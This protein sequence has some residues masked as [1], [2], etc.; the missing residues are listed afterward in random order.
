MIRP[1]PNHLLAAGIDPGATTAIVWVDVP[2]TLG[3]TR[4][5]VH[6]DEA[7]ITAY[8]IVHAAAT[9][10]RTI[11]ERKARLYDRVRSEFANRPAQIVALEEPFDTGAGVWENRTRR[12][13]G[14]A[15]R[16]TN[17]LLGEHYGLA[18]GAARAACPDA[19]LVSYPVNDYGRGR[20]RRP[21]WMQ[22]G[23]S[24][25]QSRDRT[26]E[27]LRLVA[28]AWGAPAALLDSEDALMALGVVRYHLEHH[29]ATNAAA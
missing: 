7:R 9:G 12:V 5:L 20:S 16:T 11:A 10:S 22:A 24:R 14:R 8:V 21:G 3:L 4:I 15:Q 28:R 1:G 27:N 23:A 13:A 6:M 2:L 19:R 18:L 29:T 25:P 17:F 26:L